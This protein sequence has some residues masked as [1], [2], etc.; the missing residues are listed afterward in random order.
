MNRSAKFWVL[1][2]A[3]QLAFGL[4]VFALTRQYYIDSATTAAPSSTVMPGSVTTW[5]DSDTAA[6]L[7]R[8][9][10]LASGQQTV[11]DPFEVARQA[12]EYF[13][14]K[15]YERAA[16]RYERLLVLGPNN[17][18]TYNNLGLTLH[19]LGRSGEALS[20]L[21]QGVT[22]EPAHQRS[23][24]TLGFVNSQLGNFEQA[25]SALTKAVQINSGNEV[26]QSALAMLEDLP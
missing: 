6:D 14:N 24:L 11:E 26:G 21:N 23:W 9:G 16:E 17:V 22:L 8:L 5:P 18:D 1:M 25:R 2:A 19:Y 13:A 20:R 12:N 7:A 15:Q 3:F 4:A 10:S